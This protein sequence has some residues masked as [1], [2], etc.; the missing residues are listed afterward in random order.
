MHRSTARLRVLVLSGMAAVSVAGVAQA[1]D[2]TFAGLGYSGAGGVFIGSRANGVSPDGSIAV[3]GDDTDFGTRSVYWTSGSFFPEFL[4]APGGDFAYGTAVG[5]SA[6]GDVIIGWWS[7]EIDGSHARVAMAWTD[8]GTGIELEALPDAQRQ[9]SLFTTVYDVSND[10]AIAVGLS[11]DADQEQQ[12]VTW[13]PSTGAVTP[14]AMLPGRT[15]GQAR[16]V[17]ADGR[18]IVGLQYGTG[19]TDPMV[20]WTD[21]V[22]E[23]AALSLPPGFE[24]FNINSVSPDGSI[25]GGTLFPFG[26]D[27]IDNPM[28]AG[29]WRS[30]EGITL[31]DSL[32]MPGE[33]AEEDVVSAV[34]QD[35]S[36]AVGRV[37]TH[38]GGFPMAAAVWF[39]DGSVRVLSE[40]LVDE[41]GLFEA[42]A[43]RGLLEATGISDD[44]RVIVGYG[45]NGFGVKE[46]WRVTLPS[47]ECPIDL[48]GDG[49]LTVFDFLAFGNLFDLADPRADIDGDGLFTIFD[50]LT[51]QTMFDAGC[52]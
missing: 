34:S 28:R 13:D 32:A 45:I 29:I 15:G 26:F 6:S 25:I 30:G 33:P 3:G 46:A 39:P 9:D 1:Q 50:F 2:A 17:S 41:H 35:G 16:F 40:W 23:A 27:P 48:D 18:V 21:G 37:G 14:L 22:P 20:I 31:L 4:F 51:F 11:M 42:G 36:L 49:E 38:V 44:G 10:G 12:P 43:W 7:T 24:S 47:D 5:A 8:F 19:V 52:S